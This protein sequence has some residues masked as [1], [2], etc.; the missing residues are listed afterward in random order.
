MTVHLNPVSLQGLL[1]CTKPLDLCPVTVSSWGRDFQFLPLD[2]NS[3]S[4]IDTDGILGANKLVTKNIV[5]G[6][7]K[8]VEVGLC[9]MNNIRW[10]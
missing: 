5:L 7:L 4:G 8:G 3:I 2:R 6:S 1:D 9:L 10:K